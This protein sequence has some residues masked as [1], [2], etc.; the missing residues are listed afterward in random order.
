MD[1]IARY[2][3]A[4]IS[5]EYSKV[6]SLYV[7]DYNAIIDSLKLSDETGIAVYNINGEKMFTTDKLAGSQLPATKAA[8]SE[9]IS[10]DDTIGS[11]QIWVHGNDALMSSSD[12]QFRN[13][14][15][16]ALIIA[17][18]L[19]ML[20]A[21]VLGVWFSN[22]LVAPISRI[23]EAANRLSK[24]D[25]TA[26]T[27]MSG[28]S[29]LGKLG[30]QFDSM[31]ESIE[32]E[33]QMELRLTSDVA[34]ELRTPLMAVQATV[35]AMIDGV[36]DTDVKH[37][38]IIESEIQRLSHLV[39][40]LLRLSRLEKRSQPLKEEITNLGELVDTMVI[41]HEVFVQES[42]LAI[43]AHTQPLVRAVCDKELIRQAVANLISNAVRYTPEGG[44]IDI[45][46]HYEDTPEGKMAAID[47]QDTGVGLSEEEAKMVFAR[48]WRAD[49]S[50]RNNSGGL[51][52][53]LTVVK[54]IIDR[55]HGM[56]KVEG[57]PG[58]GSKFSLL[59]PAYDEETSRRE[60]RA[61]IKAFEHRPEKTNSSNL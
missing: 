18:F 49:S 47:V 39:D 27:G 55:H 1:I 22:W 50:R 40:A 32:N 12:I 7:L 51:G 2:T 3:A 61:A 35:E 33:R 57:E 38:T 36:Y 20:I 28:S 29:E 4:R 5:D 37:L 16:Q 23:T 9:I 13:N 10:R 31:A 8:V 34:H 11:V 17:G 48:F 43:E 52:I 42:G 6:P 53:G 26:R 56:I 46:V 60:A 59:L 58:V 15:F 14:T 54:E 44:R 21:V 24:G 19:T 25:L 30:Q 41:S 45:Y